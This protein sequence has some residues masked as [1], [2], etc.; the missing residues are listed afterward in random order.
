[1]LTFAGDL[2]QRT[3]ATRW[4]VVFR[5]RAAEY[6]FPSV[7]VGDTTGDG[8]PDVLLVEAQGSG[9]CGLRLLVA[10]VAGGERMLVARNECESGFRLERGTLVVDEPVGS[11]PYTPGSAHCAGGTRHI[12]MRWSGARL[13]ER[14]TKVT[15]AFLRLD[16]TRGCV[17]R[18]R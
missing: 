10:W 13:T 16:P 3:G 8:H 7:T 15:C 17:A 6:T 14:R 5:H 9:A 4:R 12:V 1:M 11:C 2:W 18:H